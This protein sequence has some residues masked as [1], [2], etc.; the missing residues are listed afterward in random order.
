MILNDYCSE[1][2]VL[3]NN[4][5]WLTIYELIDYQIYVLMFKCV[6][7]T[8]PDYLQ[9]MFSFYNDQT[10]NLRRSNMDLIIPKPKTETLKR[11]FSYT[12]AVKWNCLP[13]AIRQSPNI[14]TFKHCVKDYIIAQRHF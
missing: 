9:D 8:A 12:G 2:N 14:D 7:G 5:K 11:S 6:N 3:F 1:A 10:Y 4:L 13:E